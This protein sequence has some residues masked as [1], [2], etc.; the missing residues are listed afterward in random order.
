MDILLVLGRTKDLFLQL[1][2]KFNDK[3]VMARLVMKI[4]FQHFGEEIEDRFY[5][6]GSYSSEV[7][8]DPDEFFTR[9]IYK[10]VQRL[11]QFNYHGSNLV[12]KAISHI[13]IQLTIK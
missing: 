7:V 11:D 8:I 5:H 1:I 13:H 10:I 2:E 6:F 9:H 12:I 4:H 3:V